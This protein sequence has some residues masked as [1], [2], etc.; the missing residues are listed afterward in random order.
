MAQASK[1][2][3]VFQQN[4]DLSQRLTDLEKLW[5]AE[6]T[7]GKGWCPG[8]VHH[9]DITRTWTKYQAKTH[10]VHLKSIQNFPTSFPAVFLG[11][12]MAGTFTV[13]QIM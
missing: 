9:K 13:S 6:D 11:Q 12:E 8:P 1:V 4:R 3:E 5:C 2:E 7:G 10:L